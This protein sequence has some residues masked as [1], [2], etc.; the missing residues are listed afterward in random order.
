MT[1]TYLS[2]FKGAIPV[3]RKPVF[4]GEVIE[5]VARRHGFTR[6]DLEGP[7]RKQPLAAIRQ[8]AMWELRQRTRLSL[9]HIGAFLGNRDH[10]TVLWGIR[11]HERR[12]GE[13]AE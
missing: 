11:Q 5:E 10:T 13:G 3:P 4:P 7:S 9:P 8:E 12:L 6:Q 1:E 2:L